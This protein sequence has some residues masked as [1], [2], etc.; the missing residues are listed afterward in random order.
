MEAM[1]G[2]A[3]I[4]RDAALCGATAE[5]AAPQDEALV[6]ARMKNALLG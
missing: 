3:A 6:E 2:L 5:S 1:H 4:L